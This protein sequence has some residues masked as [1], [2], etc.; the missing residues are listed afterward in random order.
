MPEKL[1]IPVEGAS[2]DDWNHNTFWY[3]PWGSSGVHKG[4]DIFGAKG[5]PVQSAT[6]GYVIYTGELGK[7]GNVVAVLGPKWRVHYYAHMQEVT[8]EKGTW[9]SQKDKVGTLG[10]TGNAKGKQPHLHYSIV[11]LI[12]LPW[13]ATSETQ[14]WKKMFFLNPHEK[15]L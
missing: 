10:D 13:K 9:L 6:L 1:V 11:S 3:E 15:L 12:P 4:V 7:G 8:V 2:S 14:G 5:K